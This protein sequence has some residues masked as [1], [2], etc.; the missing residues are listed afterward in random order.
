MV[1][2]H[3]RWQG[4]SIEIGGLIYKIKYK[5]FSAKS[6]VMTKAL[7]CAKDRVIWISEGLSPSEEIQSL[8]HEI[9]HGIIDALIPARILAKIEAEE[10]VL[11]EPF[12]R[13]LV[14]A[15]R[16]GGLLKE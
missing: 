14:S 1:T 11:V 9:I 16:S 10:E 6:K 5:K 4:K 3:K 2:K 15:L 8:I 7:I 13:L 12:S